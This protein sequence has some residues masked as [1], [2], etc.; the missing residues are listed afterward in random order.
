MPGVPLPFRVLLLSHDT[1]M[2]VQQLPETLPSRFLFMF[3]NHPSGRR[4]EQNRGSS[5][6]L[7]LQI[8]HTNFYY[9]LTLKSHIGDQLQNGSAPVIIIFSIW[10]VSLCE[11]LKNELVAAYVPPFAGLIFFWL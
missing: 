4:T 8:P 2:A 1:A 7:V 3:H 11:L 10:T 9:P 5:N 6:A